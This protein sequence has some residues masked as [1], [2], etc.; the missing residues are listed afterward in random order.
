MTVTW[1]KPVSQP[2]LPFRVI[3]LKRSGTQP[4]VRAADKHLVN[5]LA[6]LAAYRG[7]V[8]SLRDKL[9]LS[10]PSGQLRF[11]II[12]AM[13]EFERTL[14]Q[15]RVNAALR[16]TQAKGK[17]PDR[18]RRVVHASRIG[19]LR[20]AG[21]YWRAIAHELGV[22]LPQAAAPPPMPSRNLPVVLLP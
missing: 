22:G 18:P 21:A 11:Q 19:A 16:N 2:N 13:A 4:P 20:A 17:R 12:G 5:A 1:G 7:C 3:Q 8:V 9:D 15:E 6:D 14:I 10:T